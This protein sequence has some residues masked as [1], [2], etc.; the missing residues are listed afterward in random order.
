MFPATSYSPTLVSRAVPSALQGLTAEFG[1]GSGVSPTLQP[2][3]EIFGNWAN[4][5]TRIMLDKAIR[6]IS[7]TRLNALL[8]LHL[9]PIN[10][11]VFNEPYYLKGQGNLILGLVSR[12]YAFSAYP[13]RIQ[14]PSTAPDGTTG[15]PEIRPLRSSRTRSRSLQISYA[16]SGQRPNCLTTF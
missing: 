9:Q 7:T 13:F 11:V 6:L 12:L 8:H 4:S 2:P 14:L 5:F 3:E 16:H 10:V 15:T 1:M